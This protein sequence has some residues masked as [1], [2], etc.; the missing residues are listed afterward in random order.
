VISNGGFII[1]KYDSKNNS[2]V[3][4]AYRDAAYPFEKGWF[5]KTYSSSYARID[6]IN[7]GSYAKGKDVKVDVTLSEVAFPAGTAKPLAKG[8]I[9]VT[10]VG[11]KE[12][13][14]VAKLASGKA[15]ATIPAAALAGLKTGA[16]T[17]IVEAS[18][19]SESGSVETSN[20]IVF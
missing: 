6:K 8:N 5:T 13:T 2:M 14:V 15:E 16:Y 7:V 20:L 19:G 18:L 1:D 4:T 10:L 9:K 12:T 3:M 11:D 17:V